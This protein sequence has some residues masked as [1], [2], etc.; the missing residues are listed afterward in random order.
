[1]STNE[2]LYTVYYTSMV[3]TIYHHQVINCLV[4]NVHLV[5]RIRLKSSLYNIKSIWMDIIHT[6]RVLLLNLT[7]LSLKFL[8]Q[9]KR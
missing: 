4:N 8:I 1:M 9:N 3:Y 2:Y 7:N 5:H 6:L